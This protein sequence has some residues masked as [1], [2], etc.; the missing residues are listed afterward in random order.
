MHKVEFVLKSL[1]LSLASMSPNLSW[2]YAL[3][4]CLQQKIHHAVTT[5]QFCKTY[6]YSWGITEA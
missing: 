3:I 5:E 6:A 2:N 1:N 4:M